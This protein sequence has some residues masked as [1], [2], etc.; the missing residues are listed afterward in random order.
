M[1]V[2]AIEPQFYQQLMQGLGMTSEVIEQFS[3][4]HAA[5]ETLTKKFA[6]R[7]QAEWTEIFDKL[8]ACVTPVLEMDEAAE[9]EP[10]VSRKS[11]TKNPFSNLWDPEPAP[12]LSRTPGVGTGVS[13]RC[14]SIGEHTVEI[15]EEVG[16]DSHKIKELVSE[17]TV[18]C[19]EGKSKM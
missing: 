17:G 11:F 4:F 13:R 8:D 16:Y 18:S 6:E 9:K 1:A 2:G 15:L 5:K 10:N 19:S 7:S 14:P 12:K 3:D